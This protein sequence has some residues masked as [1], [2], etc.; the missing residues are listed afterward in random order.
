MKIE[1]QKMLAEVA[2]HLRED[3]DK[4]LYQ[5]FN[6]FVVEVKRTEKA[7]TE[8]GYLQDSNGTLVKNGDFISF[9]CPFGQNAPQVAYAKLVYWAG[10]FNVESQN[11]VSDSYIW[12]VQDLIE[13]KL[14]FYK[15]EDDFDEDPIWATVNGERRLLKPV[16]MKK[17]DGTT[18]LEM[19]DDE[20]N[21]Y[22]M[23]EVDW[24]GSNFS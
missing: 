14:K 21:F 22:K 24:T 8:G 1:T 20:S 19:N 13:N 15:V 23:N 18:Y 17:D 10:R 7:L 12:D 6:N 2:R 4:D 16:I 9:K 3:G 11:Q 5:R